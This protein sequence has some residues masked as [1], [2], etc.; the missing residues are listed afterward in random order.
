MKS[1][2]IQKP[3][4]VILGNSGNIGCLAARAFACQGTAVAMMHEAG[5]RSSRVVDCLSGDNHFAMS[6]CLSRSSDLAS[7][8][9]LVHT[10]Y[11]RVDY[12]INCD[13]AAVAVRGLHCSARARLSGLL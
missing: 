3:V 2:I 5:E 8:A 11:G 1:H 7:F 13:D 10:L 6:G 12:L 4:A 9:G